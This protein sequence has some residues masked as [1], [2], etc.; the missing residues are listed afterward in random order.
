M[1][2]KLFTAENLETTTIENVSERR[3]MKLT[4]ELETSSEKDLFPLLTHVFKEITE[5][6]YKNH[7]LEYNASM[8]NG[9]LKVSGARQKGKYRWYKDC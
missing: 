4:I 6:D 2:V 5:I 9:W 7:D 1:A 8:E 3:R